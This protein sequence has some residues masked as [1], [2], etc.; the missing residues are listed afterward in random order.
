MPKK[1]ELCKKKKEDEEGK[2]GKE[3]QTI[4]IFMFRNHF[5]HRRQLR[6][7]MPSLPIIILDGRSERNSK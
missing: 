1:R 4:A 6:D 7:Y 2:E 3:V 5:S